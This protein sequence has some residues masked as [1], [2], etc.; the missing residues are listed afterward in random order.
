M[1]NIIIPDYYKQK[2]TEWFIDRIQFFSKKVEFG[3]DINNIE[4]ILNHIE[5]SYNLSQSYFKQKQILYLIFSLFKNNNFEEP[6]GIGNKNGKPYKYDKYA[7]QGKQR[8]ISLGIYHAHISNIDE[9]ILIWY[10][11]LYYNSEL[12]IHFEYMKHPKY[13]K[14][15]IKRIYNIEHGFNMDEGEFFENLRYL[16]DKNVYSIEKKILE[17]RGILLFNEFLIENNNIF[18]IEIYEHGR[19]ELGAYVLHLVLG[20]DMYFFLDEEAEF[21]TD[22]GWVNDIVLIHAYCKDNKNNMYDIT[23]HINENDLYEHAEWI[24]SPIHEKVTVEMFHQYIDEG[25]ITNYTQNEINNLK[26]YIIDNIERYK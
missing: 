17:K 11:T 22:D 18:N 23:G 8:K 6:F 2:D 26:K 1:N 24:Q 9:D 19:C 10:F 15:I 20:Y 3:Y 16:I 5:Q 4:K 7:F 12:D 14:S 25:F 21:E 13:Y